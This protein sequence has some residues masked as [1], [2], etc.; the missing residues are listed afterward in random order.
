MYSPSHT[1]D[2]HQEAIA[3][4]DRV[5]TIEPNNVKALNNKAAVLYTL[6]RYE[7]AMQYIDKVLEIKPTNLYALTNKGFILSQFGR[8]QEALEYYNKALSID[9]NYTLALLNRGAALGELG[10]YEEAIVEFDKALIVESATIT[11]ITQASTN[12]EDQVIW[13]TSSNLGDGDAQLHYITVFLTSKTAI[14]AQANKGIALR[15][16]LS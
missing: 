3:S 9:A 6:A 13:I 15:G 4:Y 2:R 16:K 11:S 10:R 14:D 5:L 8:Y 12:K 1:Q 7:E